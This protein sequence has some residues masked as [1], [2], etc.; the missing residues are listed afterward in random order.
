MSRTLQRS[1]MSMLRSS[2]GSREQQE[3]YA[4]ANVSPKMQFVIQ[5][6]QLTRQSSTELRDHLFVDTRRQSSVGR[7]AVFNM[8]NDSFSPKKPN[9]DN[10]VLETSMVE[11]SDGEGQ[12]QYEKFKNISLSSNKIVNNGR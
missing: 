1:L 12:A 5:S 7:G 3:K 4:S 8:L 6:K 2:S 9:G 10:E 11:E